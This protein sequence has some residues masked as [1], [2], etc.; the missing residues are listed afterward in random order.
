MEQSRNKKP[1]VGGTPGNDPFNG[2]TMRGGIVAQVGGKI[3]IRYEC[4]KIKN[5]PTCGHRAMTI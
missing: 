5:C 2:A 1:G 4:V 3:N